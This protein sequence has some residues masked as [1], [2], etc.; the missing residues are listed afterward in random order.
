MTSKTDRRLERTADETPDLRG[1]IG[2]REPE[3]VDVFGYQIIYTTGDFSIPREDLLEKMEEVGLPEWMQP[4]KVKPHRAFG[5]M[6]DDLVEDGEEVKFDGHRVKFEIKSGENRYTQHVHISVYHSPDEE[7]VNANE[8]TWID[9]ELGIVKY[10]KDSGGLLFF[11]R[12]DEDRAVAPLWYDGIKQKAQEYFEKHQDLHTGDD[13]NNVVYYLARQWT[14]AVKLRDSCYFIPA[15]HEGIEEYIDGFRTLYDWIN[16]NYKTRGQPT[17]LYA[18]EIV[19]SERQREMVE[20]KVRDEMYGKVEGIVDDVIE[21]LREGVDAEAAANEV[22]ESLD[23]VES[24][25]EKHSA[26]LKT[27]LSVKRILND[28]LDDLDEDRE[29]VAERVLDEVGLADEVEA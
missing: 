11:D 10:D 8:G 19:D 22:V 28:V 9:Y 16:R 1:V 13:V 12:I 4:G 26:A 15:D 6:R 2:E 21:D 18:I 27:E 5:R 23:G 14:D 3:D 25:A 29:E 24:I 20:S 7:E 17:E